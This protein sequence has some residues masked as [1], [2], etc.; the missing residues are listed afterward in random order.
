MTD[1]ENALQKLLIDWLA[2]DAAVG[3]LLG[4][5]ARIWDRAPADP[6]FP[7][8]LIGR[9]ESRPVAADGGGVEHGLTLT[10]VSRFAGGEEARAVL[11]AVRARLHEAVLS[12]EGI[13]TVGLRIVFA[14]VF[15]SGD[16]RRTYAAVRLRAV[17]E[18]IGGA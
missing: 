7:H 10:C 16:G 3:A 1:H 6:G 5:P 2:Q 8:L 14:D 12:G 18:E 17:T 15:R 11:A 13:R 4:E 9:G